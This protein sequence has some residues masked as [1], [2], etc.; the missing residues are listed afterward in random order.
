M[1]SQEHLQEKTLA[2]KALLAIW[3]RFN[4]AQARLFQDPV[5]AGQNRR[6][7]GFA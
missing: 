6:Y 5:H 1:T 2:P 3:K 4:F 7:L